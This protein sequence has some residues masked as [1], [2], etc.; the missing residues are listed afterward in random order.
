MGYIANE[1]PDLFLGI[2]AQVPFVDICNT[3]LDDSL[4]LTKTEFPEWGNIK[5]N[6]KFFN[7]VRSYS[8]YDN[9]KQQQYPHMLVTGGISD[10]RVTYWEMTKWFEKIN[11]YKTNKNFLLLH[12]NM[13]AG[14][15]GSSGRFDYL[16]EV[17]L[18]IFFCIKNL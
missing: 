12:M 2:I 9:V 8:P 5:K 16:K 13:G 17:T 15:S 11:D 10:P 4:P 3:M 6:K 1:R 7:Y 18:D 14:H